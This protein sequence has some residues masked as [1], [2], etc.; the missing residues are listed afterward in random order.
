[1]NKKLL[2]IPI[3]LAIVLAVVIAGG[4]LAQG[5]TPP[6]NQGAAPNATPSTPS[7]GNQGKGLGRGFGFAFGFGTQDWSSF[8]AA[9][10]ALGLTP[11]Q[12]FD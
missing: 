5:N 10:Q 8:D 3:V 12:L 4:A 9:A 1:M 2:L 11:T 6:A 7:Q